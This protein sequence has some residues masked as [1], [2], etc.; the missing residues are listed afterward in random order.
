LRPSHAN[1]GADR[2]LDFGIASTGDVIRFIG[3]VLAET[4]APHGP[5]H[6]VT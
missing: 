6:A 1:T 5:I 2:A 4:K 3:V